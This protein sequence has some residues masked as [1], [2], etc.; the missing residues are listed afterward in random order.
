MPLNAFLKELD[1]A[2]SPAMATRV[3]EYMKGLRAEN[4]QLIVQCAD[5]LDGNMTNRG[6]L[7][8]AYALN[9]GEILFKCNEDTDN[10]LTREFERLL[11]DKK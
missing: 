6:V 2:V 10:E 5:F 11:E 9:G 1:E 8:V 7:T 3:I 4:E